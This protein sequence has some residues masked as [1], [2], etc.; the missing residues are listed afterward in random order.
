MEYKRFDHLIVLRVEKGEELVD[1]IR[2]V[3]IKEEIKLASISGIGA[4]DD[5][6]VGILDLRTKV[7]SDNNFLEPMEIT[8]LM[9]NITQMDGDVYLH[10]HANLS[11]SKG[12][13]FGGHLDRAVIS[14]T[15]EIFIQIY[16]GFVNRRKDL[17]TGLNL[18]E[19]GDR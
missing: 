2:Q 10:L 8:S 5:V 9:G 18:L 6:S 16:E 4:T 15:G 7:Y 17:E 14:A 13:T 12:R 19:L 3:A 1:T 11:D